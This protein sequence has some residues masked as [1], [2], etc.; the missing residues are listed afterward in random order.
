LRNFKVDLEPYI[1]SYCGFCREAKSSCPIFKETRWEKNTARGK[2]HLARALL[3]GKL[4]KKEVSPALT[5]AV[6]NC[7]LCGACEEVCQN[8]IPLVRTWEAL[9]GFVQDNWPLKVSKFVESLV[10]SK[11]I[12]SLDNE[13][14]R[15]LWDMDDIAENRVNKPAS[16]A[17]FVGC[18]TSFSGRMGHVAERMT[19]VLMELG[20]DFTVLGGKEWCCGDPLLLLGLRDE[21]IAFAKHNIRT[22][23]NLGVKEVITT[24]SGCYKTLGLEYNTLLGENL[25]IKVFH[26]SQ[27]LKKLIDEKQLSFKKSIEKKVAF[28]DPCELGRLAGIYNAP[29]EVISALPGAELVE[30]PFNRHE[31]RCCGAGGVFKVID[32]EMVISLGDRM[33]QEIVDSQA[34]I[35]ANGCPTCYDNISLAARRGGHNYR[36]V[37]LIELVHEALNL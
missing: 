5:E 37:D 9:R 34:D 23:R 19:E 26:H 1:C 36:V 28:K 8:H 20:L 17:Y 2:L 10:Q 35:V 4:S 16:L 25:G 15:M 32:P 30:L 22:L 21:A 3:D 18:V 24:C 33:A 6:L 12:F 27:F 29:R 14:E 31:A 7:T 13:E 11:N